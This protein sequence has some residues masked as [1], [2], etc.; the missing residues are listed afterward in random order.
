MVKKETKVKVKKVALKVEKKTEVVEVKKEKMTERIIRKKVFVTYP[1]GDFLIRVKNAAKGSRNVVLVPGTKLIES[2]A[3]VLKAEGYIDKIEKD[4]T[5]I[6]V[7]LAMRHKETVLLG[8][9]L[10]SKPGL[11]QYIKA[12]EIAAKRGPETYIISTPLG[13]LSS[14]EAVKKNV[15]GEVIAKVW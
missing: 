5:E 3:K 13:I 12:S 6:K 15:G 9:E 2:V 14:R 1:I 8:V 11:R 7:T 10:I 4:G